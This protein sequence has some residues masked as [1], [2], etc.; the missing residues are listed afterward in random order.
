MKR[1]LFPLLLALS[2]SCLASSTPK[3]PIDNSSMY[4]TGATRIDSGKLLKQYRCLL[5]DHTVWVV[6]TR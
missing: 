6:T 5:N 4:F 2:M 1:V 3:C